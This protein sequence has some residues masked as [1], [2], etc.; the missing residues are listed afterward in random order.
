MKCESM[1]PD[2][3]EFSQ[4]QNPR[5]LLNT[6]TSIADRISDA[7]LMNRAG[8]FYQKTKEALVASTFAAGFTLGVKPVL[9]KMAHERLLDFELSV[10]DGQKYEY[11]IVM[12]LEPGR[13]PGW[14]YQDGNRPVSGW[15]AFSGQPVPPQ[16]IA[17]SI[18]KKMEKAKRYGI[19]HRHL[20]VY[21]NIQ[22]GA[23]DLRSLK[24]LVGDANPIWASVWLIT[25]VPDW[26]G[27]A[28]LSNRHGFSWPEMEWL[29]YVNA[30]KGK[31][32]SG[33]DFYLQ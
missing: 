4:W 3:S 29:S 13:K 21:Q 1:L 15:R 33:F 26:G 27:V 11:E 14:E 17:P 10:S 31:V 9:V 2:I 5:A 28:L 8:E 30:P 19:Y 20:L 32:F 6:A 7:D 23:P 24:A 16:W 12:A 18:W 25:G 22:G